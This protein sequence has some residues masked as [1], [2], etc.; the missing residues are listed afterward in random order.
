MDCNTYDDSPIENH[1]VNNFNKPDILGK[2]QYEEE[3]QKHQKIKK[4]RQDQKNN[5][6]ETEKTN[7]S[8]RCS[9][10]NKKTKLIGFKCKCGVNTCITHKL[11]E[12]H[13]CDYDFK[14]EEK[15]R[16]RK[17]NPKIVAS[18]IEKF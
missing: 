4:Q 2:R 9:V 1:K 8:N 11:P 12:D 16:L 5:A 6:I 18:K 13:N 10:C 17:K 15:E 14:T 3:T 7:K